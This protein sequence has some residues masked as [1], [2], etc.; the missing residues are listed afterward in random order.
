MR[1][2]AV[3][4]CRILVLL[5]VLS[6]LAVLVCACGPAMSPREAVQL[7]RVSTDED[8]RVKAADVV[9][10]SLEI[11]ACAQV[12]AL[13]SSDPSVEPYAELVRIALT[14]TLSTDDDPARRE[15]AARCLG[16]MGPSDSGE[17]LATIAGSDADPIVRMASAGALPAVAGTEAVGLLCDSMA[18]ETEERVLDGKAALVAA[19][20]G[21]FE[22]VLEK[23]GDYSLDTSQ[24][25]QVARVARVAGAA[26]VAKLCKKLGGDDSVAAQ[27]MLAEIGEPAVDPLIKLL[28]SRKSSVRFAAAAA[29]VRIERNVPG[30]VAKLTAALKSKSLSAIAR[31]YAFFIKLGRK[32]TEKLLRAALLKYG[33]KAMALDFLNCGN[34]ALDAAAHTW[35]SRHGYYVYST[36]GSHSGPSWGEGF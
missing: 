2:R 7:I 6:G 25:V 19:M 23:L 12:A 9:S 26:W 4:A 1:A 18:D 27:T 16:A 34:D 32:G 22:A 11:T 8:E 36:P 29:L 10:G 20:P 17:L 35:A 21:A 28:K 14:D 3:G 33:G 31:N 30:T 13:A 5:A 24:Q 15:T